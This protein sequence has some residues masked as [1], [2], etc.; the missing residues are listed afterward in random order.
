MYTYHDEIG[1]KQPCQIQRK[2]ER[3]KLRLPNRDKISILE[4]MAAVDKAML[5][6]GTACLV[7]EKFAHVH[8]YG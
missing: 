6:C 2:K 5:W 8:F 3:P 1:N 4:R 7:A